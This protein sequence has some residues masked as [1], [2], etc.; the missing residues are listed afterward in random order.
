MSYFK[1]CT[2]LFWRYARNEITYKEFLT[3]LDYIEYKQGDLFPPK[4]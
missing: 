4:K 2:R 3:E 1:R